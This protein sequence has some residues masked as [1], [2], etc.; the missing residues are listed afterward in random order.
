[1]HRLVIIEDDFSLRRLMETNL[2]AHGF[3]CATA[4]T[5][6]AGMRLVGERPTALVI[7]DLLL[8]DVN[9]KDL[10]RQLRAEERTKNTPVLVVTAL[11]DDLDRIIGFEL[12][13]DD[14]LA[15]PFHLRELVLRVKAIIRRAES[16]PAIADNDQAVRVG[17][18]RVD[19]HRHAA[20]LDGEPLSLT[21]LEFRLLYQLARRHGRVQSREQ[22]IDA[23]WGGGVVVTHRTVDTH[24][25]RLRDKLGTARGYIETVRGVGYRFR[26]GEPATPEC[27]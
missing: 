14:Y 1:M 24:V 18:V 25:K 13:A 20:A 17:P 12:G 23:A 11:A 21:A 3:E 22:L 26:E 15:K 10:L 2:S 19:P 6:E 16:T 9:G 5:A 27:L 7:L 4:G 8:P